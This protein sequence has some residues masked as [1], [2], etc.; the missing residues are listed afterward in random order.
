MRIILFI[1]C[2]FFVLLI[3]GW[4]AQRQHFYAKVECTKSMV[5]P[6]ELETPAYKE[7]IKKE[8]FK[9]HPFQ[10]TDQTFL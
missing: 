1:F 3:L 7:C 9:W 8:F 2:A 6:S 4:A 5:D 10:L